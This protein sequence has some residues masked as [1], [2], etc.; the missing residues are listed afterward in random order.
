MMV[1][2]RQS[3]AEFLNPD[4]VRLKF[5]SAGLFMVAHETLI[6]SITR[7][8]LAFFSDHWTREGMKPGQSYADKVLAL[9]PKGKEHP[10]RASIAWL[11]AIDAIDADDEKVVHAAT[12]HRNTVAHEL[13]NLMGGKA[14]PD[15]LEAFAPVYAL[16]AKIERWWI[17]NFHMEICQEEQP[18]DVDVEDI[19]PG[20]ILALQMLA[21]VAMTDGDPAWE[22][23]RMFERVWKDP[24]AGAA[25]DTSTTEV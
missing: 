4:M 18:A 9:D 2:A 19:I 20:P 16:I 14:A 6:D 1:D 5:I 13:M 23:H 15:Y 24:T 21:E 12:D 3:W 25:D 22:L 11:R 10:L 7:H 8:P 17:V